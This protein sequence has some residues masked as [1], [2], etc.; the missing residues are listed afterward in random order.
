MKKNYH[1]HTYRCKH[2]TGDVSDYCQTAIAEGLTVLGMSDHSALPDDRWPHIRMDLSELPDYCQAI[3]DA[4]IQFPQ[5]TILKGMECEFDQQY[6]S[7]Y[8]EKL[9]GELQFDYLIGAVHFVPVDGEWIGA[10]GGL[11]NAARLIAYT[12]Y[13]IDS[14]RSGLFTFMA[15]P[16]LFGNCYLNWDDNT[17]SAARD[18]FEAAEV[19]KIPLEINGYGLRKPKISTP[20]GM[21]CMYPWPPFWELAAEYDIEVIVNSDAHHPGDIT[22]NTQEAI[23]IGEKFLLNFANL[24]FLE[25]P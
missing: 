10:Y 16:D 3:D 11:D 15:H 5:L 6:V 17:I 9:L 23:E 4:R 19:L 22:K 2:A 13:F 21:R 14:M 8:Q 12:K 20:L 24:N 1:T 18:I 7:F 25:I